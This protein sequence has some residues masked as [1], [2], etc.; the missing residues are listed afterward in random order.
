MAYMQKPGRGNHPKTGHGLPSA[1][2][3]EVELTAKYDKGKKTLADQREKGNTPSGMSVSSQT[4]KA[5]PNLPMHTTQKVGPN[6]VELNSEGGFVAKERIPNSGVTK[7]EGAV[8]KRNE[9]TTGQQ[10]ANADFYNA[11]S[12]ATSPSN[13][14]DKQKASLKGLGKIKSSRG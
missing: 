12:G 1:L 4:G 5:T 7:L 3:Q 6:M 8:K 2:H 9:I 14:S 11:N 13:L 10:T